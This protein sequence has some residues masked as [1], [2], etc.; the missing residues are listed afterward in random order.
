[1]S[2]KKVRL[3]L[4]LL[5]TVQEDAMYR[6]CQDESSIS[7]S[8]W[9][10][11][12]E[13]G[14]DDDS[15][16]VPT[17]EDASDEDTGTDEDDSSEVQTGEDASE[18]DA[19]GED[20]GS[21]EDDR[22]NEACESNKDARSDITSAMTSG[23]GTF[24][25]EDQHVGEDQYSCGEGYQMR[26]DKED[27][28][29]RDSFYDD[30]TQESEDDEA[31]GSG[32]NVPHEDQKRPENQQPQ[33]DLNGDTKSE[34]YWKK[35]GKKPE[36]YHQSYCGLHPDTRSNDDQKKPEVD[37]QSL[38]DLHP[39]TTSED[40]PHEDEK[41]EKS[42]YGL[43]PDTKS[44]D[45]K[46]KPENQATYCDVLDARIDV[47][48]DDE[49]KTEEGHQSLCDLHPDTTSKDIPPED[50]EKPEKS[51]YDLQPDTRSEDD[52]KNPENQRTHCDLHPDIRSKDVLHEDRRNHQFQ[53]DLYTD[54]IKDCIFHEDEKMRH[55]KQEKKQSNCDLYRDHRN[56]AIPHEGEENPEKSHHNL[57]PV[58]RSEEMKLENKLHELHSDIRGEDV[59][60]EDESHQYIPDLPPES[61]KDNSVPYKEKMKHRKPERNHHA[62]F[63]FY[64]GTTSDDET[65]GNQHV[66]DEAFLLDQDEAVDA[67]LLG[68]GEERIRKWDKN[69]RRPDA[70]EESCNKEAKFVD[71]GADFFNLE[72]D[73]N[74]R[75]QDCSTFLQDRLSALRLH[76]AENDKA[77]VLSDDMEGV[78]LS[79]FGSFVTH[80]TQTSSESD[81][82]T[83]PK[84]FIRPVMTQQ[85]FK[86]DDPVAK[87]FQ[88]KQLWDGVSIPGERDHRELRWEIRERLAYQPP[89]P[90]A[91]R[92]YVANSYVIPTEKKRSALRWEVRNR[93]AHPELPHKFTYRF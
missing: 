53:Y 35:L 8:F 73:G 20:T 91:R 52:K 9:F 66:R 13:Q 15:P 77:S 72:L 6:M 38:C 56:E 60:R 19:T 31:D 14:T 84:S 63:D 33:W 1:M 62:H 36:E 17:G 37:H 49:R 67:L 28:G 51:H 41:P 78:S 58:I 82:R 71:L 90:K 43:Q 27:A 85:T 21:D 87:Y 64:P 76:E 79:T 45:D 12:E 18:E 16:K 83:K 69:S 74:V 26:D 4:F 88:Y 61:R 3:H 46:K 65:R 39:D 32:F 47:T 11:E 25:L 81:F 23:Y 89:A 93:M 86:K 59:P 50:K 42:P 30:A 5:A 57:H 29:S 55:L 22:S 7:S 75:R 2:S 70:E 44:E 92:S 48:H 34:D 10:S 24:R 80:S 68:E 54:T 40:I